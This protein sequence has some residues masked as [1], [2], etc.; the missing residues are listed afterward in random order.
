[1]KAALQAA[2]VKGLASTFPFIPMIWQRESS[3][4][5][6]MNKAFSTRFDDHKPFFLSS[7]RMG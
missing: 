4:S 3:F 7:A 1:M 2:C 6:R 5:R